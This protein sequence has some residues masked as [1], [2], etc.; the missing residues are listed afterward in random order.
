MTPD[1]IL[2]AQSNV[3][4]LAFSALAGLILALAG[5]LAVVA[6]WSTFVRPETLAVLHAMVAITGTLAG[7]LLAVIGGF[8]WLS[9]MFFARQ[10]TN[11][12]KQAIRS[13]GNHAT[14]AGTEG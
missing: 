4:A 3:R 12:V 9:G 8:T 2:K 11:K 7:G 1:E 14:A 6:S 10:E 13:G 5:A